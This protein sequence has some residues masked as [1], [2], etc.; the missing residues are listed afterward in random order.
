MDR[1]NT[2]DVRFDEVAEGV[3]LGDL[4][5]GDRAGM[6]YWR[7]DPGARLPPHR[8]DNEQIGF[9]LSGTLTALVEGE[10]HRLEPG[11]AYRF[12]SGELHGAENRG[13]EPAVGVGVLA[14]PREGP[15]WGSPAATA[16]A[17][18]Q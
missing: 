12:P 6:K 13:S 2:A 17:D 10:E 14:P 3:H 18:R 16:T 5:T 8:H 15:N 1:V 9:M 4:P 7:I 11:D